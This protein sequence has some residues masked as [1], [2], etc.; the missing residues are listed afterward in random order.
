MAEEVALLFSSPQGMVG[1]SIKTAINDVAVRPKEGSDAT[2][3][4]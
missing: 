1:H 4:V 2:V 3:Q